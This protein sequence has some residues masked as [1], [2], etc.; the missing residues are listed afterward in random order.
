ML[1]SRHRTAAQPKEGCTTT[2]SQNQTGATS[3]L[4][5]GR[6]KHPEISKVVE[7]ASLLWAVFR[8]ASSWHGMVAQQPVANQCGPCQRNSFGIAARQKSGQWSGFESW[9]R[10]RSLPTVERR[11]APGGEFTPQNATELSK[12]GGVLRAVRTAPGSTG[13]G[14]VAG[15]QTQP[16]V[17]Q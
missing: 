17:I 10:Q 13:V 2:S 1:V 15:P 11:R 14:R 8:A 5:T 9:G 4:P 7:T 16:E 12:S 3:I 6:M